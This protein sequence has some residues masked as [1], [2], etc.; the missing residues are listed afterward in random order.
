MARE[1]SARKKTNVSVLQHARESKRTKT[2]GGR[3]FQAIWSGTISFSL[4]AI[5][6]QMVKAVNPG[7]ISFRMLH[8]KDHSP[9]SRKMMCPKEDKIVDST[10]IVRGFEIAP[11]QYVTVTDKELESVSPERSRTIE[12]TEFVDI[13]DIDDIYYD[14]P[15]YLI[16]AK[17]G[18]KAYHLLVTVLAQ[19]GKA[20]LAKFVL[21]EREYF[22]AL[23]ATPPALSL[24]TLHYTDELI[25]DEESQ[26]KRE[27]EHELLTGRITEMI[28][29]ELS[30][31]SPERYANERRNKMSGLLER[32][33]KKGKIVSAPI[34]TE[35]E[36]ASSVDLVNVLQ[37]SM[38]KVRN[39]R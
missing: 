22:V 13:D 25:P 30:S 24:I 14:R 16:P 18:E 2:S 28:G 6:V 8:S 34:T 12:I 10:D 33:M 17:G 9:L 23:K 11:D 32:K 5:P 35:E 20:G 4:V 3:S 29:R 27:K 36:E 1:K 39:S 21:G 31:F 37:E 7:R 26:H 38:R 19:T 15:Y